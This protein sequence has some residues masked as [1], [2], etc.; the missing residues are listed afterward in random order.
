MSILSVIL[1]AYNEEQ[2][3]PQ[4][5]KAIRDVLLAA[6]IPYEMIFVDDGSGDGT[7]QAICNEA[8]SDPQIKGVSFSRNFGKEAAIIA[9]L[10]EATGDCAIVMDCDLQDPPETIPEMVALWKEGFEIVEGVK[11]TRGREGAGYGLMSRLFNHIMSASTGVDMSR[12]SDFKLLDR[13]V[14]DV[15]LSIREHNLFF[16]ATTSLLGFKQTQV[17]FDVRERAAGHSK[18][19]KKGLF[20]YAITNITSYTNAPMKIVIVLGV[21]MLLLTVGLGVQTLVRYF[22]GHALEGFTTVIL[23]QLII[24]SITLL[25]LGVIGLDISRIFDEVRLRPRYV[26]SARTGDL[27]A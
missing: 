13:K 8:A 12:A 22:S 27:S 1:P 6:Q 24:G 18:W 9:G 20:R 11:R 16:R 19:S 3:I 21:L 14:I 4:A 17:D 26:I 7:W 15:L 23:L 10:A 25:G 5:A 2:M